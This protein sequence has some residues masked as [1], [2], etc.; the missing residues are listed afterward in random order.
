M[1]YEVWGDPPER[2]WDKLVRRGLGTATRL[3]FKQPWKL[4][5]DFSEDRP[6]STKKR[7]RR[8]EKVLK[9][10]GLGWKYLGRFNP[11]E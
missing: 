8:I 1:I 3:Y 5:F 11:H 6:R 7:R 9:A 4:N 2:V 10:S